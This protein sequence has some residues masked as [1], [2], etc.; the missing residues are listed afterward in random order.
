MGAV[1]RALHDKAEELEIE[2]KEKYGRD[3]TEQEWGDFWESAA[4]QLQE[5]VDVLVKRRKEEGGL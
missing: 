3:P 1:K 4:E 5:Q 2:F